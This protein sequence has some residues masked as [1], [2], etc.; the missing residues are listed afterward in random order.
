M[1]DLSLEKRLGGALPSE[2]S[3]LGYLFWLSR[4]RFWLYLA[5]PVIVGVAYAADSPAELFSPLAVA[6][7]AYFL[8]PANVYLYGINDVFDADIDEVNP[9]KDDKEVRYEGG[10]LVILSVFAAGAVGL[11]LIP[12]LGPAALVPFGLF[13]LLATEYSAPPLRFKT[14][15]ILDSISNGLYAL[16]GIAAYAAIAGQYPPMAAIVGGWLWTMAMHTFS[17]IPDIE[18]DRNAGIR[19][20]ATLLGK[21]WTYA[22]C[23]AVWLAAAVGFALV[24]PFLGAVLGVY[25]LLVVVIALADV[26]VDR[27]YWWYPAINT[28]VG[29]VLTMAALWVMLYA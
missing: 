5:G 2:E 12:F 9:K 28:V 6:L 24:H 1:P 14:T 11:V 20:T 17:A 13:Y 21:E 18:P 15:P 4:P 10:P 22:Y 8:V 16:P 7:F 29:A 26:P 27:A 23:G 25:P 19:T 3:S